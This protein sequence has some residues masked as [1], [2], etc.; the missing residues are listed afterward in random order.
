MPSSPIAM[1]KGDLRAQARYAALVEVL[2]DPEDE[3]EGLLFVLLARLLG[4]LEVATLIRMVV[5]KT[6]TG[7]TQS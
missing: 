3:A 6:E 1:L 4:D 7:G 2:D 5:R